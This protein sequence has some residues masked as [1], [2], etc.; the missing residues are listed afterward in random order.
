M[1]RIKINS[2]VF[3]YFLLLLTMIVSTT[4]MN[5]SITD[6]VYIVTS[7][8]YRV[9]IYNCTILNLS[10]HA[11]PNLD[12]VTN[13]GVV[14]GNGNFRI[15]SNINSI[16]TSINQYD[17]RINLYCNASTAYNNWT[18]FDTYFMLDSSCNNSFR[19]Y[20]Y[21]DSQ[22]VNNTEFWNGSIGGFINSTWTDMNTANGIVGVTYIDKSYSNKTF[23]LTWNES[24]TNANYLDFE[25]DIALAWSAISINRNANLP[26]DSV[27]NQKF[28]I[29]NP[30]TSN[31]GDARYTDVMNAFKNNSHY[32][33]P[34]ININWSF[35]SGCV[36]S[37]IINESRVSLTSCNDTNINATY[38]YFWS[39]F[40]LSN[41]TDR[42]VNIKL[43]NIS[44]VKFYS[45]TGWMVYSYDQTNW[46]KLNDSVNYSNP[47]YSVTQYFNQSPVQIAT[48]Y[49]YPNTNL[50][51]LIDEFNVSSYNNIFNASSLGMSSQNRSIYEIRINNFSYTKDKKVIYIIG[52]QHPGETAGNWIMDGMIRF[53]L[54]D[55][56]RAKDFRN[57]YDFYFVPIMNPDGVFLGN[58]RYTSTGTDMNR[59][60][61]TSNISCPEVVLVRNRTNQINNTDH[62][63]LSL[64]MQG[65][66][67]DVT[68]GYA[69][70]YNSNYSFYSK[71][72]LAE[73]AITK[74]LDP[75][76]PSF[77][78][79]TIGSGS[80]AV[81]YFGNIF[82]EPCFT[83]EPAQFNKSLTLSV[84]NQTG[85][86]M[87]MAIDTYFEN[88]VETIIINGGGGG[89]G[90]GNVVPEQKNFSEE[91][92]TS[93]VT[94]CDAMSGEVVNIK[95]GLFCKVDDQYYPLVSV[96]EKP[97]SSTQIFLFIGILII[98]YIFIKDVREVHVEKGIHDIAKK[99]E[100]PKDLKTQKKRRHSDGGLY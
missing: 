75:I 82:Q 22:I 76:F 59:C 16:Y 83:V 17:N 37:S 58:S 87:T 44:D 74:W 15:N 92:L 71:V 93:A 56:T 53:L 73:Q 89:G 13:I 26:A 31:T 55:D 81:G 51:S 48:A 41:V 7:D 68:A 64:D 40:N 52:R 3:V 97:V 66:G 23:V 4:A 14:W 94:D 30:N 98:L 12:W 99:N 19:I 69:N 54:S 49:P 29:L 80:T 10:D 33:D 1:S 6:G 67:A 36:N 96:A 95:G 62:I 34:I 39:S 86:N 35:D 77:S 21:L 85:I 50:R 63:D 27:I 5:Y 28:K 70:T 46:F 18:F 42:H 47:S 45:S 24:I 88:F 90:G 9:A 8:F 43:N 65:N 2:M 84:Y 79:L 32:E 61:A 72:R 57:K 60:W 38:Q 100:E 25:S 78:E 20:D 11:E 91:Q